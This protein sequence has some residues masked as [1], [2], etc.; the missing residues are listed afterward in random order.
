MA[1]RTLLNMTQGIL[2]AM[3]SDLV[4]SISDSEEAMQ[5]A[6]LIEDTYYDIVDEHDLAH[7]QDLFALEGLADLTKPT[8]MRLPEDVSK[9]LW[10]KYDKRLSASDSRSYQ[11]VDYKTPMEFVEMC[12]ARDDTDTDNYIQV[13]Y[14]NNID[15]TIYKNCAPTWWT[16]FDDE[17]IVFDSYDINVDDTLH[18]AKTLCFGNLRPSFTSLDDD[19]TPDLPENLFQLL[20]NESMSRCMNLWRQSVLPKVEQSASRMRVRAQ[21]NKWREDMTHKGVDY[22]RRRP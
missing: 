5:V 20:Y 21:R 17:Y 16:S 1:K 18:A 4:N 9:I 2:S 19:F 13:P 11:H 6:R 10:I 3:D 8:H 15:L 12:A 22:G 7:T 14:T